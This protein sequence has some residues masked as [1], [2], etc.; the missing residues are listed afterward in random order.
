MLFAVVSTV[1]EKRQQCG[2]IDVAQALETSSSE[3][4]LSS[5]S[6]DRLI[7]RRGAIVQ[8]RAAEAAD[9]TA[10]AFGFRSVPLRPA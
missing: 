6:A 3:F 4:C 9:P 5:M 10:Q 7:Q 2:A 8:K 1:I